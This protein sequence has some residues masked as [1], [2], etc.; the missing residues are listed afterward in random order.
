MKVPVLALVS[1]ACQNEKNPTNTA[2]RFLP[3]IITRQGTVDGSLFP[4]LERQHFLKN[5]VSGILGLAFSASAVQ[6]AV[7]DVSDGN[8]LPDGAAQFGRVIRARENLA[9][10]MQR[11]NSSL[12]VYCIID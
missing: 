4:P 5:G 11:R 12:R 2:T 6:S 3:E 10:C 8:A 9:V 1:L 7:A